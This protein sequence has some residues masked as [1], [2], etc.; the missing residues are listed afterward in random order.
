MVRLGL[1]VP[2]MLFP[3]A[4]HGPTKAPVVSDVHL[5]G[6]NRL[7]DDDLIHGLGLKIGEP[8]TRQHVLSACEHFVGLRL[9][10]SSRC[11]VRVK[12]NTISLTIFVKDRRNGLPVV[13]S[14]FVWSTRDALLAR[15]KSELPFFMPSLPESSGLTDDIIRVLEKVLAEEG[16]KATV[17]YDSS[18]W[19]L[20]GMNVFYIEGISTPV[21]SFLVEGQNAPAPEE[22]QK[23]AHFYTTE[24]FSAPRLTWVIDWVLRDFYFSRG[25]MRPLVGQPVL[26][27]LGKKNGTYPVRVSVPITS[28][29]L[30][31]FDSANFKGLARPHASSLA[32][33]WKLK[34]G[35]P[36]SEKY[37]DGFVNDEILHSSWAQ[38]SKN[39]SETASWCAKID[40]AT[41]KVD[42]TIS[43]G[44]AAAND[45]EPCHEIVRYVKLPPVP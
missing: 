10:D 12:G 14:N 43:V 4:P 44:V 17:K 16:I 38:R 32:S 1:L 45:D 5:V 22:I 30:F 15:L 35:D 11:D 29:D 33:K 8:T 36:Y 31:T 20:R 2:L 3:A 7:T 42:V 25:Y 26:E 34:P 39:E 21:T 37:T 18:Y 23:W 13:F 27:S 19:T 41:K 6:T 9:F 40:D 24:E 28:G